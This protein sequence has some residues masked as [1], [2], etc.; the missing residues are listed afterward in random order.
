[1]WVN[2]NLFMKKRR[3]SLVLT[4]I[5]IF[6]LI[7]VLLI[8]AN[9]V[10]KAFK[11][12]LQGWK[13]SLQYKISRIFAKPIP[14]VKYSFSKAKGIFSSDKMY[15]QLP[16]QL[17]LLKEKNWNELEC[18]NL[19][20]DNTGEDGGGWVTLRLLDQDLNNKIL[21]TGL[22]KIES[23][24]YSDA[25]TIFAEDGKVRVFDEDKKSQKNIFFNSICKDSNNYY[26]LF[27]T[28]DKPTSSLLEVKK[29]L[30][31]GG[32]PPGIF[33]LVL[34]DQSGELSSIIEDLASKTE[35]IKVQKESQF[36]KLNKNYNDHS[37]AYGGCWE[38]LGVLDSVVYLHC[39][40]GDGGGFGGGI[41]SVNLSSQ[42]IQ[43]LAFCS[44]VY[45]SDGN[46]GKLICFD[47]LAKPYFEDKNHFQ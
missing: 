8:A 15:F 40:G 17:E 20:E 5:L 34:I 14:R 29:A 45:P 38:V 35:Y 33:H 1:M 7:I 18:L 43:E 12:D 37:M 36:T 44:N 23:R 19:G 13:Y 10:I 26:V 9:F 24:E 4:P 46:N 2:R 32:G 27:Y 6:I 42:L 47:G 30:A 25:K 22:Q 41:V 3:S 31:G 39:G 16:K 11:I 21:S 28:Q